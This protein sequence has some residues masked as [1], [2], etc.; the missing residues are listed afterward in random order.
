MSMLPHNRGAD[1]NLWSWIDK[2]PRGLS[3]HCMSPEIDMGDIVYQYE[4]TYPGEG[5]TLRS[6]YQLLDQAVFFCVRRAFLSLLMNDFGR[7]K[8]ER[9]SG[10]FHR[11][12]DRP[13]LPRGWDT[14]VLELS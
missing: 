10:S 13:E 1:P 14:P 5:H 7:T 11:L 8:Q 4:V 9:D 2:T 12:S 3:I 6:Y